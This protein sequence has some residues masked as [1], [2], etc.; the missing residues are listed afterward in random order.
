TGLVHGSEAAGSDADLR[1]AGPDSGCTA[2]RLADGTAVSVSGSVYVCNGVGA[3]KLDGAPALPVRPVRGDLIRLGVA[4][5]RRAPVERVIR[6]FFEDRPI[7]VSPRTDGTIGVGA[8][9]REDE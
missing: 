2:V 3:A 7:Y 1:N 6:G 5:G 8:T 9:T 4:A